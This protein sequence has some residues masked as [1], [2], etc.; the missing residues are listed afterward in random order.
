MTLDGKSSKID[1]YSDPRDKAGKLD[2][3]R[4]DITCTH[5]MEAVEKNLYGW[6][7]ECPNNSEKCQYMHCLPIGYILQRDKADL[8]KLA[9]EDMEDEISMEE[10][11]EEERA[12]LPSVGLTPVTKESLEAWKKRRDERKQLEAEERMKQEEKKSGKKGH[13]FMSGRALFKFDPTLFRDDEEA[14]GTDVYE[15]KED[16]DLD[17]VEEEQKSEDESEFEKVHRDDEEE[18][19]SE[20]DKD[21]AAVDTDLFK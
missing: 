12:K 20:D 1:I 9:L 8:A 17:E 18:H 4:T 15:E 14:A 6:L 21:E 2:P 19:K 10:K 16:R 5:F 3:S 7:W 13:H 11:I